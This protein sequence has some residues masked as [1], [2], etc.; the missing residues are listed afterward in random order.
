MCI[1][2]VLEQNMFIV[3]PLEHN[4][5][6]CSSLK[7]IVLLTIISGSPFKHKKTSISISLVLQSVSYTL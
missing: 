3:K 7:R 6:N 1:D 2:V 5:N 4:L